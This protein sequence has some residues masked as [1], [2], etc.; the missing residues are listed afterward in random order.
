M[1]ET[2]AKFIKL[3][4]KKSHVQTTFTYK[5]LESPLDIMKLTFLNY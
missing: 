1:F 5:L 4:T 3:K 2:F